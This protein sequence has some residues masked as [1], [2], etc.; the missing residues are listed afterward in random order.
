MFSHLV[1]NLQRPVTPGSGM[2][3][4]SESLPPETCHVRSGMLIH[5]V[6]L[7]KEVRGDGVDLTCLLVLSQYLLRPVAPGS[8][9]FSVPASLLTEACHARVWHVKCPCVP[10]YRGLSRWG[11]ACLFAL[12][13]FLQRTVMPCLVGSLPT[14]YCLA[15]V[16]HV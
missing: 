10:T 13:L 1:S 11:L 5:L 2:F 9:M 15:K 3:I 12:H 14:E 6:S 4:P 16:G 8:G 7:P